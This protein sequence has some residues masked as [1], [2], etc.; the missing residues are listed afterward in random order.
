MY[1]RLLSPIFFLRHAA[2]LYLSLTTSLPLSLSLSISLSL[3]LLLSLFCLFPIPS[4]SHSRSFLLFLLTALH[5]SRDSKL[6]TQL[7]ESTIRR[8][9]VIVYSLFFFLPPLVYQPVDMSFILGMQLLHAANKNNGLSN[10]AKRAIMV[11]FI[12]RIEETH[13]RD[14]IVSLTVTP[15]SST[16]IINREDLV[17]SIRAEEFFFINYSDTIGGIEYI[18]SAT[19]SNHETYVRQAGKNNFILGV[20]MVA[21]SLINFNFPEIHLRYFR[22]RKRSFVLVL[23]TACTSYYVSNHIYLFSEYTNF[24][25]THVCA[26]SGLAISM[27]V[28]VAIMLSL[29]YGI[30]TAGTAYPLQL[31]L[32]LRNYCP[33]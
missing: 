15:L 26:V 32:C 23:P 12:T 30:I 18:T 13:N 33:L 8:I 10:G 2:F 27:Y 5:S 7:K 1:S 29:G 24:V 3:F 14:S 4:F 11:D 9:I 16:P 31:L 21:S 28:F 19:F 20:L 25:Y 6:G 22:L 17:S